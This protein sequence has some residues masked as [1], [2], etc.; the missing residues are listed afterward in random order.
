[1]IGKLALTLSAAAAGL[2]WYS[3]RAAAD[4]EKQVPADGRFIKVDGARLHYLD[5]DRAPAG[6][7]PIV[8]VHGLCGQLRNFTYALAERLAEQHRVIVVDRPGS[9]Y[10]IPAAG[11]HPGLAEQARLV[12]RLIEVLGLEKPL[13]VGHSLGGAISLALGCAHPE[14][15]RGLALI[16][17][18]TQPVAEAPAT[19]RALA[20]RNRTLRR[21]VAWTLAVPLGKLAGDKG[22]ALAFAPDPVP[23]DFAVRG[24]AALSLR[25]S[26]FFAA[27]SDMHA[28]EA[29][30]LTLSP[31]YPALRLPVDVIYGRGDRILDYRLHG[32]GLN[33]QLPNLELRVVEGGH[34][35]LVT[36][37]N[38]VAAWIAAAATR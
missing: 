8:M 32:E 34:M 4:S 21:L 2:A 6:S 17:P 36:H 9:G 14:R 1:M 38:E 22:L 24:G 18:L 13:L 5:L 11:P 16:A 19:F 27:S 30:M 25:P 7:A 33:G 12:A 23:A 3:R 15:I 10:S 31:C 29:E 37:A 35:L 28:A 26:A 20:I